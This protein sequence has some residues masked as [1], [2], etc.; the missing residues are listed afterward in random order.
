M[1]VARLLLATIAGTAIA[2]NYAIQPALA[3]VAADLG[4]GLTLIG[5]VPTAA[6]AG[7]MAGFALLL[8]LTDRIAP[9]RLVAA[10]LA[11]LATAL[12]VAAISSHPAVLPAAYVVIGAAASV[13]AQA[14]VIAGRHAP[15]GQRTAAIAT[16]AAGMSA[17]ILLSR[18]AGGVLTDLLGW[19]WMLLVFAAV[20]L[21]GAVAARLLLPGTRPRAAGPAAL[22]GDEPR[23]EQTY[24]AAL[25]ALPRQL[26][27]HRALRW[28]VAS[29]GLWYLAF[30]LVWVAL[31]LALAPLGPTVIGLYSLAGLLGFAVLPYTGRLTDRLNPATVIMAS[32][33]IA[34]VGAGLL[35]T[36]LDRP[37]VTA[38]GLALLDAGLFAAQA[39]NQS[40]VQ[41]L[42]PRH[43][44]SLSSVYLV[45][46]FA[47][48]AIGAALAAPLLHS[49]G[50]HGAV[51]VALA[52]LLAALF[53]DQTAVRGERPQRLER[54]E[55]APLQT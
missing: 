5:L 23:G 20:A 51:L 29:G 55:P 16:V 4:A 27:R 25:A 6:L 36:G 33:L 34:A 52:A 19:R 32:L 2:N 14:G 18:L 45:L 31:A 12:T 41:A 17:G 53:V 44:G 35:A 3:T 28:A 48:G 47:V 39:A 43:S 10:Q 49:V 40:R 11:V 1:T 26:H 54:D 46:Y 37:A 9:D 30:H 7:C 24:A 8:P 50:W 22:P 21:A 15:A 42:D 13:A 38:L